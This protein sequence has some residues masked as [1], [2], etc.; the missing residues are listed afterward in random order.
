MGFPDQQDPWSPAPR[1]A[2]GAGGPH[3]GRRPTH[4]SFFPSAFAGPPGRQGCR[5]PALLRHE[6]G[7]LRRESG[8]AGRETAVRSP[9]RARGAPQPGPHR[10]LEGRARG[11]RVRAPAP[12]PGRSW[13]ASAQPPWAA[14]ASGRLEDCAAAAP[15]SSPALTPARRPPPPTGGTQLIT[16]LGAQSDCFLDVNHPG[17]GNTRLKG[18]RGGG[19][20]SE[21]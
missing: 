18:A 14:A 12:E 19:W 10:A 11:R 4:Q 5:P 16:G 7:A 20:W 21:R 8:K 1:P 6:P 13:P 15:G 3:S 9:R 2:Q 17:A